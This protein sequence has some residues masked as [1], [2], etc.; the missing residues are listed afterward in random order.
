MVAI[1]YIFAPQTLVFFF[2]Y[3]AIVA[4]V[5]VTNERIDNTEVWK[6]KIR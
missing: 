3:K 4:S 2:L 1:K 6:K 5:K